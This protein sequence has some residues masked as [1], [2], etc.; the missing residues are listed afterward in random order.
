[1]LTVRRQPVEVFCA[2][3]DAVKTP[4]KRHL[5]LQTVR[6]VDDEVAHHDHFYS[7][8]PPRLRPDSRAE[9]RRHDAV[10]PVA[11]M[12]QRPENEPAPKQILAEQK[13][14]IGPKCRT[15]ELL[16]L[17][18]GKEHLK[19]SKDCQEEEHAQ[20]HGEQCGDPV[21]LIGTAGVFSPDKSKVG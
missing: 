12:V 19:R 6:P 3:M 17:A 16:T 14:Q 18:S 1:V 7:L 20:P 10:Q 11:K 4:Q 5:V 21:H 8:Q 9:V 15:Q 2:V 13:L